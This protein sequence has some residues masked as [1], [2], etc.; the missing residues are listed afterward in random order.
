MNQ[1]TLLEKLAETFSAPWN[2]HPKF[3]GVSMKTVVSSAM[4]GGTL[5]QHLVRVEPGCALETHVHPLQCELHL[6]LAGGG[7]AMLEEQESDYHPGRVAT[8]P[9]GA[10]HAVRANTDGL[11]L[12]ASFS[13]ALG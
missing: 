2:P 5:S 9:A 3:P 12:L 6:V 4:T 11:T 10:A 13:P 8:I 1:K 7:K